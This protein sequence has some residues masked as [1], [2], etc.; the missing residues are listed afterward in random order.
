M[1]TPWRLADARAA[2]GKG[3]FW[4]MWTFIGAVSLVDA[5][6]VIVNTEM[7]LYVEKN[8][9]CRELIRLDPHS[10]RYFLSAKA[11]GT[12]LVLTILHAV[13]ARSRRHGLAIAGG[14]ATYQFWLLTYL[15]R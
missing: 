4:L 13:F 10:L 8:L 15:S 2:A 3:W 11:C 14:V 12:L 6:L 9:L 1:S 7:I 5:A